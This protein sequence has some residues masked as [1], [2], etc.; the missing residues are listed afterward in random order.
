MFSYRKRESWHARKRE[1][2][3]ERERGKFQT[4]TWNNFFLNHNR[5]TERKGEITCRYMEE[6]CFPIHNHDLKINTFDK[7]NVMPCVKAIVLS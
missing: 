1:R 5:S 4:D 2:E 3:R 6:Q 7:L